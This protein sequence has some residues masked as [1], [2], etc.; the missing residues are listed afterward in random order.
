[1]VNTMTNSKFTGRYQYQV[2]ICNI[3]DTKRMES[4]DQD[5]LPKVDSD[6]LCPACKCM[7]LDAENNPEI[8]RKAIKYLK[9]IYVPLILQIKK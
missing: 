6:Y 3:C 2:F 8:L 4:I 1:M 9:Q 5:E 7:L